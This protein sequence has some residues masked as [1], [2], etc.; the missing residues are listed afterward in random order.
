[1]PLT[2]DDLPARLCAECPLRI[3]A[4]LHASGEYTHHRH[5]RTGRVGCFRRGVEIPEGFLPSEAQ[6][7]LWDEMERRE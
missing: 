1:M 6:E 4:A 5:P 3:C 7:D 2:P